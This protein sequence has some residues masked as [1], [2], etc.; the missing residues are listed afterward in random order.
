MLIFGPTLASV[1]I[2]AFLL[3]I[4]L[5]APEGTRYRSPVLRYFGQI[6]YALYLVHQPISG[7]LHGLLLDGA[8]DIGTS[9]QWAVTLLSVLV[10]I[11]VA[12]TSW[13]WLEAPI[14]NWA[15]AYRAAPA[16]AP[17]VQI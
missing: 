16:P 8:P 11:A 14:L 6:S 7:L 3:A 2:A 12:A 9:A 13:H 4:L 5:G 10:S 1:G 17:A 15:R